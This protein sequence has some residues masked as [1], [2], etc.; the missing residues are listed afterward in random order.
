VETFAKLTE[1]VA[2]VV[3]LL[4][5]IGMLMSMFLGVAD[6]FG[7]QVLSMP[8]AGPREITESTMVLIVFGALAY[9][10]VRRAHIRVELLYYSRSPRTQAVMDVISNLAA[11][12]FYGLMFWQAVLEV[13]FSYRIGEATFGAV[14]FPLLPA[15]IFLAF[16]VGLMII[17]LLVDLVV[18][19]GRIKTGAPPPVTGP[20]ITAPELR[21]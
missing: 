18:D 3:L 20:E 8:V 15:R 14:R 21:N 1:R 6:I 7:T 2:I 10:Q 9:T 13:E 16:G 19:I 4:G 17:R 11:I 5:G 12:L